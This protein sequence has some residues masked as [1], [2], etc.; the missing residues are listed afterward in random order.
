MAN[1]AI[2]PARS[3]SS[4]IPDK[5]IRTFRGVPMLER[6]IDC[7]NQ[8]ESIDRV[9]VST[10]SEKYA[11]LAQRRNAEVPFIRAEH[12][13][14]NSVATIDVIIDSI[15][16]LD[17]RDVDNVVC[18]YATN[19]L[20]DHRILDLAFDL[21]SQS[22]RPCYVTPVV[23]YGFPPQ[24]SLIMEHDGTARMRNR[25]YMYSNSQHLEA[26]YHETAQFWWAKKNT[27]VSRL[28]MQESIVPLIVNEAMQQDIDTIDDWHLAEA[29]YDYRVGNPELWERYFEEIRISHFF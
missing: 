22:K 7:L 4:R 23:K 11:E 26:W 18:V 1:V 24:R 10:D 12:L 20:L 2:I 9:V 14:E 5:N 6:T 29:K 16:S 19:P 15:K 8:S 25:D 17:L 27:W 3:G 13:S 28:G 21:L